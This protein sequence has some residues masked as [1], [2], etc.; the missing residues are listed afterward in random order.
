[1]KLTGQ[2]YSEIKNNQSI[3][4]V[5]WCLMNEKKECEIHSLTCENLILD[6]TNNKYSLKTGIYYI[7]K[8]NQ[9]FSNQEFESTGKYIV[10]L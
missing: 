9:Y 7:Y 4:S 3:L 5:D 2:Q 1:M 8:L 10:I 6:I